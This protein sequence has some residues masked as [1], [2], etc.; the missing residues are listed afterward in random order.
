MNRRM[1]RAAVAGAPGGH[2][3][4]YTPKRASAE[5]FSRV[6][7]QIDPAAKP[8]WIPADRLDLLAQVGALFFS[9]PDLGSL[10]KLRL[11]AGVGAFS[12]VGVTHT[13]ASHRVMDGIADLL[14]SPIMP[15]DAL[16]CTSRSARAAVEEM[17]AAAAEYLRWQ[18]AIPPELAKPF[19]AITTA[20]RTWRK[21][22]LAYFEHPITNAFTESFN[23][24]IRKAYQEGNGYSFEVLRAKVLFTDVMQR[25]ARRVEQVKVKRRPRFDE[26]E[27][28]RMY[29]SLGRMTPEELQYDVRN[30]VKEV[31][32][33]TD[34][35]TLLAE[36]DH[37]P[38][39]G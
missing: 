10:A 14:V 19:R 16:I 22:I 27:G 5:V 37:W 11:R 4:G 17:L 21:Q 32:L 31:T 29:F 20:W 8:K 7:R 35:S 30:V 9:G 28:A 33:G 1:G 13:V 12:L 36:I 6:V 39:R 26:L 24:K 2:I 25:K 38:T 34:L 3:W 23:A 15:W 18:E